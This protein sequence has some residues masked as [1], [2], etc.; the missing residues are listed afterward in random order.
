MF[1][2]TITAKYVEFLYQNISGLH[3]AQNIFKFGFQHRI[4]AS[5]TASVLRTV[6]DNCRLTAKSLIWS[7]L[8]CS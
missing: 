3:H 6:Q 7:K 4:V 5:Y 1:T 2:F 8:K